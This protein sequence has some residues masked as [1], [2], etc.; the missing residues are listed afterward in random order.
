MCR[1]ST[2]MVVSFE[3]AGKHYRYNRIDNFHLNSLRTHVKE[4]DIQF[5]SDLFKIQLIPQNHFSPNHVLPIQ[6]YLFLLLTQ[7]GNESKS[8]M[9]V[10]SIRD[11]WREKTSLDAILLDPT[12]QTPGSGLQ[13]HRKDQHEQCKL[14]SYALAG[15]LQRTVYPASKKKAPHSFLAHVENVRECGPNARKRERERITKIPIDRGIPS[16]REIDTQPSNPHG[17][18]RKREREREK[19]K[20]RECVV[21][22]IAEQRQIPRKIKQT[23]KQMVSQNRV[24]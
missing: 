13:D 14:L 1:R 5:T 17:R 8:K 6:H 2:K 12:D 22:M 10:V 3:A 21:I 4:P 7:S 11:S 23:N 20:K 18:M 19:E 16:A 9:G 24:T 15:L